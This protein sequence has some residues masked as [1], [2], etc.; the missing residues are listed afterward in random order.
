MN[1]TVIFICDELHPLI[2]GI[3]LIE[4]TINLSLFTYF[5]YEF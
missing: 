1:V 2:A 4:R 5:Y 3:Y